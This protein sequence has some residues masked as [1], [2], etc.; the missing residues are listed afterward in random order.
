LKVTPKISEVDRRVSMKITFTLSTA[1]GN[2]PAAGAPPPTSEQKAE[3]T[4]NVDSGDTAV[5]GGLVR[6]NNLSTDKKVPVLGDIPLLGLLF[7]YKGETKDKKEVIIFITPSIV[8][9]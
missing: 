2:P 8:E 6:Q 5:I 3:T 1:T 7:R 4:V 9:N